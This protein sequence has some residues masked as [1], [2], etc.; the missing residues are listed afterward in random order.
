[1]K[2][3]TEIE[4]R[5]NYRSGLPNEI[6]IAQGTIVTPAARH[7]LQERGA[8]LIWQGSG[9]K[10]Q[11]TPA[12]SKDWK[13]AGA[14]RQIGKTRLAVSGRHVHLSQQD[15]EALFGKGYELTKKTELSQF[16]QYSAEE[17]VVLVGP[18]G[19]ILGVRVLGPGRNQTQVEI[20]R[21]DG[22]RLGIIPPERDSGDLAGTP[23]ITLI[24]PRGSLNL[25]EGVITPLRH[26]HMST[27]DAESM[28]LQDH[29]KVQVRV[30][31]RRSL[32]FD[33]VLVRVR[34]DFHLEM[35][36]DTDEA[37]AASLQTEAEGTIWVTGEKNDV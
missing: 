17:T 37:N 21:T 31:G 5:S 32:V 9:D 23:G 19:I 27:Q 14:A 3:L 35:H 8:S 34:E 10:V 29:D 36:V 28:G 13:C 7:Y 30:S 2:V 33:E 4:L 24:G 25:P 1:M 15:V 12:K 20:S 6:V 16:G 11:G 22:H 18:N 26:I